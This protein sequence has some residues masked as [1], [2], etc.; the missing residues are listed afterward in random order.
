MET[1]MVVVIVLVVIAVLFFGF[2]VI[3]GSNTGQTGRAV[4]NYPSSQYAGGGCGR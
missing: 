1:Y 2:T 4:S 3:G